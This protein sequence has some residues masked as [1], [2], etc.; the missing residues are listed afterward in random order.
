[1]S[2][3]RWNRLVLVALVILGFGVSGLM[4]PELETAWWPPKELSLFLAIGGGA[5]LIGLRLLR[6]PTVP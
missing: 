6:P 5:G 4:P 2:E 1:M 3:R